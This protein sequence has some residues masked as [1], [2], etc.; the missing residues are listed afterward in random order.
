M[1]LAITSKETSNESRAKGNYGDLDHT[2]QN[3]SRA[4]CYPECSAHVCMLMDRCS[5]VRLI[6]SLISRKKHRLPRL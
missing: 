5:W 2:Y 6:S 1:T 4:S 3:E